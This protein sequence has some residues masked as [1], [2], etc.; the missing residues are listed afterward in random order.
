VL[1]KKKK[2]KYY[3]VIERLCVTLIVVLHD[4]LANQ[5]TIRDVAVCQK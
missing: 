1:Q 2:K 4:G 3:T 5:P